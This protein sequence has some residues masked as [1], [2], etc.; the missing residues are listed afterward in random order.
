MEKLWAG[1]D[2]HQALVTS[3]AVADQLDPLSKLSRQC[4]SEDQETAD[5]LVQAPSP[6]VHKLVQLPLLLPPVL[7]ISTGSFTEWPRLYTLCNECL[8]RL[9]VALG[10]NKKVIGYDS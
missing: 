7:P 5:R 2:S 10:V 6:I 9:R 4:L 3:H 1:V 8:H